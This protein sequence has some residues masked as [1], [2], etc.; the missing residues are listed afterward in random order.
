MP[1][2]HRPSPAILAV[3]VIVVVVAVVGVVAVLRPSKSTSGA[4]TTTV[5]TGQSTATRYVLSSAYA[6]SAGFSTTAVAAKSS[7]STGEKGCPMSAESAYA[8]HAT[9]SGLVSESLICNSVAAATAAFNQAKAHTTVDGSISLP[10]ALG[11][12]A[13]ASAAQAHQYTVVWQHGTR[14]GITGV[15]TDVT[16][17]AQAS[18]SSTTAPLPPIT[19]AQTKVLIAAALVQNGLFGG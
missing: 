14:V 8:S 1:S 12:T 18:T 4:P 13:F 3:I 15:D 9:N 6:N 16:A 10:K 19:A 17:S 11:S 7:T 2:L 5:P